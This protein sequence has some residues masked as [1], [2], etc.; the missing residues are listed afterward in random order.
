M[1]RPASVGLVSPGW[2]PGAVA[3]GIVSYVAN[4]REGLLAEGVKVSVAAM[5]CESRPEEPDILDMAEAKP[6]LLPAAV[7]RVARK[8]TKDPFIIGGAALSTTAAAREQVARH[9]IELLEIEEAYGFAGLVQRMVDLPMV[10][11]LHGPWFAGGAVEGITQDDAFKRR[12]HAEGVAFR[13]AL[14]VTSPARQQLDLVRSYYDL[15]LEHAA[16]IPN[17]AP[18]VPTEER[19][20]YEQCDQRTIL[21][22]GRFDR[23]KGADIVVKA[24]ARL[25]AK[26]GDARLVLVGPDNGIEVNGSTVH[27]AEFLDREL[28]PSVRP[29]ATFLGKRLLSDIPQLRRDSFVT[30]VASRYENHPLAV[31]EAMAHGCPLIASSTGGIPEIIEDGKTGY[32]FDNERADQLADKL[33]EL[34]QD[35]QRAVELGNNAASAIE[36]D[37]SPR[38][39]ANTT[40]D[41]YAQV[42]DRWQHGQK[43]GVRSPITQAKVLLQALASEVAPAPPLPARTRSARSV[44]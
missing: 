18:A 29:R 37:Y 27:A 42:L 4:V 3:N 9:A 21:C 17:P 28:S 12:V 23:R 5:Y 11:R 40:L 33:E 36:R 24:F 2:P 14:G 6:P 32:L 19:W 25:G 15:P 16:V 7:T 35:R 38:A 41:Y 22:V 31:L 30:V 39:V 1:R 10:L 34:F 26:Y 43:R 13:T 44:L 20:R 8:L